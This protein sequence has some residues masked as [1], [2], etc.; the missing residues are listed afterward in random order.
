MSKSKRGPRNAHTSNSK[1][2][3]GDDYGVGV[4]NPVGK[5]INVMGYDYMPKKDD[6][7]VSKKRK[8]TL[9]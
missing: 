8:I 5:I 7:K 1:Y 4:R 6:A 3:G 2:P 9:A